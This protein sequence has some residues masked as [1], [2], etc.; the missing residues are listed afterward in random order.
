MG[1]ESR[2]GDCK[3]RRSKRE[4]PATILLYRAQQRAPVQAVGQA[5]IGSGGSL[6]PSGEAAVYTAAGY[7][8]AT[9]KAGKGI[10]LWL[11]GRGKSG[12]REEK[13]CAALQVRE[14]MEVRTCS[15]EQT[16]QQTAKIWIVHPG[17]DLSLS[18]E[19]LNP[20]QS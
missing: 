12:S 16:L 14:Q 2:T 6:N 7:T 17:S 9:T 11:Q 4:S 20:F 8:K 5:P 18:P 15:M 10:I 1:T 19:P 13:R 3:P